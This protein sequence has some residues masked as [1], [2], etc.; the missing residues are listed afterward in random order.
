MLEI[1][2]LAFDWAVGGMEAREERKRRQ[3]SREFSLF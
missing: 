3:R 1:D 2:G